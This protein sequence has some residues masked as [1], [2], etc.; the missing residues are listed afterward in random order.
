[1]EVLLDFNKNHVGEKIISKANFSAQ[2][3]PSCFRIPP[4]VDNINWNDLMSAHLLYEK[5]EARKS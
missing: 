3:P 5:V 2:H 1:M 4:M